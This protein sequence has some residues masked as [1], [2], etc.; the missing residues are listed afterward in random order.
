MQRKQEEEK[1]KL[2]KQLEE[3]EELKHTVARFQVNPHQLQKESLFTKEKPKM[4]SEKLVD[5]KNLKNFSPFLKFDEAPVRNR[6]QMM[7]CTSP[8]S[9]AL[10]LIL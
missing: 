7:S 2:A 10:H 5:V 6:S 3:L 4:D 1:V 8:A 9:L